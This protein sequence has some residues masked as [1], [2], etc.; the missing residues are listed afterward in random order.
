MKCLRQEC[1]KE[2][3]KTR[4]KSSKYCSDECYYEAKKE[5]SN[6][7]YAAMKAPISELKRCESILSY[8]YGISQLGKSIN[9]D[10]LNTYKFNFSISTGEYLDDH[11]RLW[12]LIGNYGYYIDQNKTLWIWKFTDKK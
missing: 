2:I 4:K 10:D 9:A 5:R 1:G 3:S 8:L 7:R 6:K 11:N 12:K